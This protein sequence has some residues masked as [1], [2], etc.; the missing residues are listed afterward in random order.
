MINN[1][2]RNSCSM[3]DFHS[4]R[5]INHSA[6]VACSPT[7]G[8]LSS[9]LKHNERSSVTKLCKNTHNFS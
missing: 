5:K 6:D 4:Q 8:N 1:E 3:F 7:R 2:T 9:R